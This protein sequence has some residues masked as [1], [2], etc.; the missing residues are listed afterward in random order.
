VIWQQLL[1]ESPLHRSQ[2][3]KIFVCQAETV[4]SYYTCPRDIYIFTTSI[5]RNRHWK[6]I[7]DKIIFIH[8]PCYC[9]CIGRGMSE[10][11][12]SLD[13]SWYMLH[14]WTESDLPKFL[15][16]FLLSCF[17]S[18]SGKLWFF[19]CILTVV[20]SNDRFWLSQKR[21]SLHWF[22]LVVD[23]GIH[24]CSYKKPLYEQPSTRQPK[25]LRN[26]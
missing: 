18:F 13:F 24:V 21:C 15:C 12:K 9:C 4:A 14:R 25:I 10:I 8:T 5:N 2:S 11:C 22:N 3:Q 19:E 16:D 26:I 23:S 6:L 7:I 20:A 1:F 17:L